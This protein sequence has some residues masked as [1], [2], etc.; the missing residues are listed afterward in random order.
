M[1][2]LSPYGPLRDDRPRIKIVDHSGKTVCIFGRVT[3]IDAWGNLKGTEEWGVEQ[4]PMRQKAE[5]Q[6]QKYLDDHGGFRVGPSGHER[7]SPLEY[8]ATE[9]RYVLQLPGLALRWEKVTPVL[10]KLAQHG[11]AT[12]TVEQLR[13]CINY[14]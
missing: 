4:K 12:R 2:P 3:S 7:P 9:D 13:A 8:L 10:D 14:E 11:I 5:R 6:T 1:S